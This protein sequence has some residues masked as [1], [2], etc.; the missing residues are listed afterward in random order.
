MKYHRF[1]GL[2]F[3]L[4]G[5]A[6]LADEGD[7]DNATEA[8]LAKSAYRILKDRCARC[9]GGSAVQAG[10]DVLSRDNLIQER[11]PAGSTFHFVKPG[12]V[13]SSQLIDSV[14]GGEDSYMPKS[15]SPEAKAMTDEEKE[16][17]SKWV[18][19]GAPFPKRRDIQHVSR[20]QM[21]KAMRDY[22][23]DAKSDDRSSLRFFSFAHLVNNP[24]VTELDLRLYRAALSKAVNSLSWERSVYLPREVPNSFGT[25]YAVDLRE[26]GWDKR[27]LWD[28]LLK[29][30]P[31]GLKYGF[32]RDEELQEL[33]KDVSKFSESELPLLRA[34][35]FVVTAT[36]PPLYHD[37][38]D[39]P[40]TLMELEQ[41]LQLNIEDN[42]LNNRIQRS[43]FAKS[44]VSRQNRLLERHESPATAYFWIS[45]DF[46][47]RVARGDLTRFPLG[48]VFDRNPHPRQAF[49]HDGGEVIWSLPNGMQG[50]MLVDGKG[51]RLDAGPIEVVFDRAAIL[52][53]PSI[54]NGVSCMYCH[55]AG[56]I[57]DFRDE[58]R[59]AEAVGGEARKKVLEI[60][61][62][63]EEMQDSTQRDSDLFVRALEKVV[64]PFLLEDGDIRTVLDYP[65]P[66]GKVAEMYSR[67]LTPNEVALE[68]DIARPELL[69]AKI[70]AN[71]ELLRYG[72]GT[73][74][75]DPPGT[76]KR[77][78]WESRDGT[79]LMQDVSAE[80]RIGTPVI[81]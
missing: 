33:S 16:L 31:Y 56:M 55:R 14:A 52:G 65:E 23:L 64:A 54:I 71:R 7:T 73:M 18:A 75:Q 38:L 8:D 10:I 61:P 40:D 74:I 44:G 43:G 51:D 59:F 58:I 35:W 60:Y 32:V 19:S 50:Y 12:D 79:S 48:P 49:Q 63:H 80:L 15:G 17:L 68:L 53:T 76:L 41:M 45:Y 70:E 30:Y 47:P 9:H 3:L 20:K 34:D 69:Q 26:L 27:E 22:L 81:P 46:L 37:F 13:D 29:Q 2:L 21:Y 36:Q 62:T 42:I 78:K 1:L 11:G 24:A 67:D 25:V 77:E 5:M 72:L 4:P 6:L 66:V 39:I 57:S 28:G